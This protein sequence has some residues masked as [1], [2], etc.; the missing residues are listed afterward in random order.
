MARSPKLYKKLFRRR[1]GLGS[2]VSLWLAQDHVLLVEA[3]MVTERYQRF[4]LADI[5]GFFVGRSNESRWIFGVGVVLLLSFGVLSAVFNQGHSMVFIVLAGL[6]IPVV[7]YGLFL[8]RTS[9]LYVITAVQRT[10]WPNVARH[11][12]VKK[13]LARLEPLIRAAQQDEGLRSSVSD[14]GADV[15][16]P[17]LDSVSDNQ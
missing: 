6:M 2:Y 1:G 7:L 11:R 17:P 8:G 5:Q 16:P 4:A 12:Q 3:N 15:E 14:A 10:Q 9:R 13:L